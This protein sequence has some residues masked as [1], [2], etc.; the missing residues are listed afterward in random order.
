MWL[1]LICCGA[2]LVALIMLKP[3]SKNNKNNKTNK[4]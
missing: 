4:K 2:L 3:F 1:H